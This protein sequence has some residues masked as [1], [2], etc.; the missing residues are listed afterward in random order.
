MHF[1]KIYVYDSNGEVMERT[2]RAEGVC[3]PLRRPTISTNQSP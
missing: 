2:E 1:L 3:N